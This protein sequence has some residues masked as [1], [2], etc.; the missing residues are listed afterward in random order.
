MNLSKMFSV[1]QAQAAIQKAAANSNSDVVK[2]NAILANG[3]LDAQ[4]AGIANQQA[5]FQIGQNL[6][7]NGAGTPDAIQ[8]RIN[9]LRQVGQPQVAAQA[10]KE[11]AIYQNKQ[12]A[13][14]AAKDVQ[15][16][17][18]QLQTVKN[19]I[20]S[21]IQSPEQIDALNA[22]LYPLIM[23]LNPS[24]RLTEFSAKAEI[25]PYEIKLRDNAETVQ[26][27]TQDLLNYIQTQSAPTPLLD[28]WVKNRKPT[29][30][31]QITQPIK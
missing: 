31:P 23:G 16:Q 10:E 14:Q 8:Q 11:Y 12:N 24:K 21:P 26:K 27:K 25:A 15:N 20:G 1:S 5:M 6:V 3:A 4:K 28:Q 19:R 22:R 17:V 30:F 13:I 29:S 7:N 9:M 18:S 2:Q